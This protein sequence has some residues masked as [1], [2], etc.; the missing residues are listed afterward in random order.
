MTP[1]EQSLL[2]KGRRAIRSAEVLCQDG[3]YDAA[4]SRSY[5][6][7]FYAATALLL[8]KGLTFFSHAAVLSAYGKEYAKNEELPREYHLWLRTAE[9]VRLLG[10]YEWPS[11][12]NVETARMQLEHAGTFLDA[13][14]LYLSS[15]SNSASR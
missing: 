4:C 1:E 5:Y 2:D 15:P 12:I 9:E 7:M 3:D 13:A 11:G 6:A 8:R 14:L 10:D